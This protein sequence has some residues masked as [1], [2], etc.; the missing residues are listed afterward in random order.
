M[1]NNRGING[2]KDNPADLPQEFLSELYNHFS[3]KAIR[4]PQLP[5]SR[6]QK[7]SSADT[8]VIRCGRVSL[9]RQPVWLCRACSLIHLRIHLLIKV[10]GWHMWH[11]WLSPSLQ[12]SSAVYFCGNVLGENGKERLQGS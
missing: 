3:E 4:F 12:S 2:P 6:S 8:T 7:E 10:Q 5:A 11:G 1:R 9:L